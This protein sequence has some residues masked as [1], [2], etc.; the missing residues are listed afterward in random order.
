MIYVAKAEGRQRIRVLSL[1]GRSAVLHTSAAGKVW[2][3][4]LSEERALELALKRGL[5]KLTQKSI[6]TI[7]RLRAELARVRRVGFAT[8]EEEMF[9]GAS[10]VGVAIRNRR[11]D[12]VVGAVVL[13]GPSFRLSKKRLVSY[14]P[15]LQILADKLSTGTNM[16]FQFP[17]NEITDLGELISA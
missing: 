12:E 8:V 1:I 13:S 5:P 15:L 3:A 9:E 2:L 11:G 4:S 6:T 16:D 10:S 14:V 7:D 17:N